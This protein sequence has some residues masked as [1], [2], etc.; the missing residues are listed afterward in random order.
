M[1]KLLITV[2]VIILIGIIG[3]IIWYYTSPTKITVLTYHDFVETTPE[4]NMQI[5]KKN[6]E[7]QMKYLHDHNYKTLKLKDIECY[8]EE[9]CKLSKKSVL[10]TMDDGWKNELLIAAP[11][12]KKYKLD[13]T[14]FYIGEHYN[15]DNENFMN[16][17]DIDKLKKKYSNIE[18]ANHSYSLHYE[19]AYLLDE[20]SIL[21]DLK[22]M[23]EINESKYYAY[24]Y[25]KYSEKYINSLKNSDYS[26]AF[27]FGPGE[28]HRKLTTKD[29]KYEIPRLNMST[30]MPMWKFILRLNWYE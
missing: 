2:L 25:G 24:P 20:E 10:I 16:E 8:L 29:N 17:K 11:I 21:N 12:L 5:S 18:L 14:I 22:K 9:K 27:T 26:L 6:F 1:K 19:E 13:A 28:N 7:K 30:D 23:N 4:N 15:G 3:L